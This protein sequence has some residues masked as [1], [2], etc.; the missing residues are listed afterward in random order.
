MKSLQIK[1]LPAAKVMLRKLMAW[2]FC[3]LLQELKLG[4]FAEVV[5]TNS[6]DYDLYADWFRTYR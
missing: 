6:D 2:L 3:P 4:S 1:S 5:V